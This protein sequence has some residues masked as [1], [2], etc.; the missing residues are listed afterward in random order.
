MNITQA[1]DDQFCE[2]L[3]LAMLHGGFTNKSEYQKGWLEG[4]SQAYSEMTG[5]N[6]FQLV[7]GANARIK[8]SGKELKV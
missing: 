8:G 4:Y 2:T 7:S 5:K 1:I 3:A 6:V